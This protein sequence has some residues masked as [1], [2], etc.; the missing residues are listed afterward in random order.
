[1]LQRML[2]AHVTNWNDSKYQT[3]HK[4]SEH[5]IFELLTTSQ[6]VLQSMS[7]FAI[8]RIKVR[9]RG[10]PEM[11]EEPFSPMN[12]FLHSKLVFCPTAAS[13]RA[14]T[15]PDCATPHYSSSLFFRCLAPARW[16]H[17]CLHL[18]TARPRPHF[19]MCVSEAPPLRALRL[20]THHI[21]LQRSFTSFV[22]V[23]FVVSLPATSGSCVIG[24]RASRW[25]TWTGKIRIGRGD[26]STRQITGLSPVKEVAQ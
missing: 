5:F 15:R 20:W 23:F 1:M 3:R 2:P 13:N 10:G 16:R 22:I 6:K 7:C 25:A 8:G 21:R 26:S 12:L 11:L 17:F 24:H 19:G 9:R 14:R 18:L 4:R